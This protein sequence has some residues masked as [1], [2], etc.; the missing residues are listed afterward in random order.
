MHAETHPAEALAAVGALHVLAGLFVLD[1]QHAVGTGSVLRSHVGLHLVAVGAVFELE[2]SRPG[3]GGEEGVQKSALFVAAE[4]AGVPEPVAEADVAELLLA[5]GTGYAVGFEA[6][7]VNRLPAGGI[8]T[9]LAVLLDPVEAEAFLELLRFLNSEGPHCLA[10]LELPHAVARLAVLVGVGA[11]DL[12]F[13]A[14]DERPDQGSHGVP[15]DAV[16]APH[17][18]GPLFLAD[19]VDAVYIGYDIFGFSDVHFALDD[20][21]LR[22]LHDNVEVSELFVFADDCPFVVERHRGDIQGFAE[23]VV[24]VFFELSSSGVLADRDVLL[25]AIDRSNGN[26]NLI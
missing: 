9:G 18:V 20:L 19:E 16:S 25:N 1:N 4:L 13:V 10:V 14:G 8:R 3:T 5:I 11:P 24:D 26:A 2:L 21:Y 15:A 12:E 23:V 6:D 22:S 7:L 17:F